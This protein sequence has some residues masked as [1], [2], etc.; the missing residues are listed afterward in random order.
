VPTA[1]AN[2]THNPAANVSGPNN[3]LADASRQAATSESVAEMTRIWARRTTGRRRTPS[4]Q[5]FRDEADEG[6]HGQD[7]V[8]W[9]QAPVGSGEAFGYSA[10]HAH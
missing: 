2:I 6:E 10:R 8:R 1:T 5:P 7:R 3:W 9:S 4:D